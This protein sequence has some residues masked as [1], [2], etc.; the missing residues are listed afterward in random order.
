MNRQEVQGDIGR[1]E[2]NTDYIN[3]KTQH[4]LCTKIFFNSEDYIF[5]QFEN[6][7]FHLRWDYD[8]PALCTYYC[9]LFGDQISLELM[10]NLKA[11]RA[12]ILKCF[13]EDS[14]IFYYDPSTKW[15]MSCDFN[16]VN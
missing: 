2:A 14:L 15:R 5:M 1:G 7:K 3:K 9:Q 4:S 12:D 16:K 11:Q 6:F 10:S 13:G 8:E